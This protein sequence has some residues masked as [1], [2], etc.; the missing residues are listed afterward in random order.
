MSGILPCASTTDV[1]K[2]CTGLCLDGVADMA[3]GYAGFYLARVLLTLCD[4]NC[5]GA[6]D[7]SPRCAGLL[8]RDLFR[9]CARMMT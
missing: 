3:I 6:A 7:V 9:I 8:S 5:V 2:G 4:S 1:A